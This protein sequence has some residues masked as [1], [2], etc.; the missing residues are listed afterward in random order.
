MDFQIWCVLSPHRDLCCSISNGV[1]EVSVILTRQLCCLQTKEVVMWLK[2][3]QETH[4]PI[5][6]TSPLKSNRAYTPAMTD[7]WHWQM[8]EEA[9][10]FVLMYECLIISWSQALSGTGEDLRRKVIVDAR[11]KEKL[12]LKTNVK[13]HCSW[14][15]HGSRGI[16]WTFVGSS[17]VPGAAVSFRNSQI[18]PGSYPVELTG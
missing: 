11:S 6:K 3:S 12:M 15:S 14:Q 2:E 16:S 18:N 10:Y 17:Q 5:S 8:K 9:D 1:P 4:P 13:S 7:A